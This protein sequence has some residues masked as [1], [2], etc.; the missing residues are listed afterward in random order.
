MSDEDLLRLELSERLSFGIKVEIDKESLENYDSDWKSWEFS[1]PQEIDGVYEDGVTLPCLDF[2]DGYIPFRFVKP[3]LYPLSS[4]TDQDVEDIGIKTT[5]D[6]SDLKHGKLEKLGSMDLNDLYE[7][8]DAL[9]IRHIDYRGLLETDLAK[10]AEG[11]NI[12]EES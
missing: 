11:K 9:K 12:Y 5:I 1:G 6:L 10:N 4:L 8:L 2:W 3:Y 7:I